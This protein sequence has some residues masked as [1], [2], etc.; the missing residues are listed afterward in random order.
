MK[1]GQTLSSKLGSGGSLDDKI[2]E[3]QAVSSALTQEELVREIKRSLLPDSSKGRILLGEVLKSSLLVGQPLV[4]RASDSK[5][6][7]LTGGPS[8]T[9]P[10]T[11]FS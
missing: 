4:Y 11:E 1:A 2:L 9:H 7:D 5:S 10:K 6:Q 8:H 3:G